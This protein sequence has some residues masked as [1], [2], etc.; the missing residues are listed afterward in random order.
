MLHQ[1]L[2]QRFNIEEDELDNAFRKLPQL[3]EICFGPGFRYLPHTVKPITPELFSPLGREMLVEPGHYDGLNYHVGQFTAMMAAAHKTKKRLKVI[4][5]LDLP[6]KAFEQHLEVLAMMTA[7]MRYCEHFAVK[8]SGTEALKGAEVQ[9][10]SMI[11]NAPDLQTIELKF[12]TRVYERPVKAVELSRLFIYQVHWPN[13][14]SL[15]LQG[16]STS[17]VHLKEILAAH[18][19]SLQ[20]LEISQI[21]L[22]SYES[23]G[24][25][26]HSSWVKIILFLRE[27]LNLH[28]MRFLDSLTN[29]GNENWRVRE[30]VIAYDSG[31]PPVREDLTFKSRVERYVVE[32]GEFPLPWPTEIEDSRWRDLLLEFRPKL[33]E[34][35]EFHDDVSWFWPYE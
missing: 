5:A 7:D 29:E 17:E 8:V 34:T 24:K 6:W 11:Q 9:I 20:S 31:T 3:E 30:P 15:L 25:V 4:R 35:W 14:K 19:A 18:A 12:L 16:F 23:K 1:R 22:K 32:G 13:L 27:S 33:D 2:L 21:N 10:S 28:K 26:H